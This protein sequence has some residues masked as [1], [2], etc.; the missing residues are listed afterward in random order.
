VLSHSY[1]FFT[2]D[3][4]ND[5]LIKELEEYIEYEKLRK[6]A[7]MRQPLPRTQSRLQELVNKIKP[8]QKDQTL[9]ALYE[10]QLQANGEKINSLESSFQALQAM[11]DSSQTKIASLKQTKQTLKNEKHDLENQIQQLLEREKTVEKTVEK[12]IKKRDDR[13]KSLRL[14]GQKQ[15]AAFLK[16]T[17]DLESTLE[18]NQT[19]E[20]EKKNLE[21]ENEI[22]S[23]SIH[24]LEQQLK[25]KRDE[26]DL[27][28]LKGEIHG[29]DTAE[30]ING[31]LK[32]FEHLLQSRTRENDLIK[33]NMQLLLDE[34]K[35]KNKILEKQVKFMQQK[36][37]KRRAQVNR[38][39]YNF[40]SV[41]VDDAI[42]DVNDNVEYDSDDN[43]NDINYDTPSEEGS[44]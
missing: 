10:K 8:Q 5:D 21:Y 22:Q 27:A 15:L 23:Q 24:A 12:R 43:L 20:H 9:K 6:M 26:L 42:S 39:H 34:E 14:D 37:G 35:R 13:I 16:K 17:R 29:S 31:M 41:K 30:C 19:L 28:T 33:E 44:C 11:A 2:I 3:K 18:I 32:T 1:I 36:M 38:Y 4:S 40:S 7:E 25:T